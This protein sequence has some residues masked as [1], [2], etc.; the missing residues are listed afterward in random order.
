MGQ[1]SDSPEQAAE[2]QRRLGVGET[3][4]APEEISQHDDDAPEDEETIS[5]PPKVID[6][7]LSGRIR[8]EWKGGNGK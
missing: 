4:K 3:A 6:P 2:K 8:P 7:R 5:P 1:G